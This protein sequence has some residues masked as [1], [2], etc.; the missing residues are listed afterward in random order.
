MTQILNRKSET[1]YFDRGI[2]NNQLYHNTGFGAGVGPTFPVSSIPNFFNP[3]INIVQGTS[4][5]NRVGDKVMPRG[6]SIKLYLVNKQDRPNT[7]V[8]VIVAILPKVYAGNVVGS[9]FDPFQIPNS[10]L[11]GNRMLL[12]AD[13]D[14][15]VKFLYDRV[16]KPS[17]DQVPNVDG[18]GTKKERH[19]L[20]K[21]W[22]KR[23]RAGPIVYDTG[24]SDI[25]NRPIAVYCIPYEQYSTLESDNIA[26]CAG[27]MRLYYKDY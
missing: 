6:M 9:Q 27:L 10:G 1:K 15:G 19:K 12:P 2:E 18:P 5:L 8:R 11:M 3:W 23:K 21:L 4:R 26:S 24:S 20:V 7:M 22:I 16:H 17:T 13:S 25:V 14:K